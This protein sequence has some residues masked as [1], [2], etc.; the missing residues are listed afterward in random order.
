MTNKSAVKSNYAT[1]TSTYLLNNNIIMC[2]TDVLSSGDECEHI[3]MLSQ[4]WFN[5][6]PPSAMLVQ[7]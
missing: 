2:Y 5:A 3:E 6:G 7:Q 4:Y 1:K